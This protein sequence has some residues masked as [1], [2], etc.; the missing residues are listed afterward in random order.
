MKSTL[1]ILLFL[2]VLFFTE[3]NAQKQLSI[4]EAIKIALT[5]NSKLNK[6]K[7]GLYADEAKV[8]NAYG[9]LLPNLSA[10][11][12]MNWQRNES[13]SNS[14]LP[15]SGESRNYT[16]GIGGNWTLFDGLSN[17]YRVSAGESE[18]EAARYSLEKFKQDVVYQTTALFYDVINS[19]KLLE[20]SKDNLAY[21]K[22]FLEQIQERNRLG[23]VALADVYAQQVQAGT[24]E[25]QYI[26]AQNNVELAKNNLFDF[27]S[28]DVMSEYE[29]IEPEILKSSPQEDKFLEELESMESLMK[30]AIEK[31]ADYISSKLYY[32]A[33]GSNLSAARGGLFPSLSANYSYGSSADRIS[34]LFQ[35]KTYNLGLTLSIPIF[36]NW[37]TEYGI[38]AAKVQELSLME[39]LSDMERQIKIDIKQGYLDLVASRKKLEVSIKNVK[40]AYENRRINTERYNLGAGTILDFLAGEKNYNQALSDNINSTFEY[41]KNR[42]KLLNAMGILN[43]ANYEN[44]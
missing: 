26:Q 3:L 38:Q 13:N 21:N 42:D 40:A 6:S 23:S 12:S 2:S 10:S 34:N 22:K 16:A 43:Y 15:G 18:L 5:N 36:S 28:M 35:N 29:I 9:S 17:I 7:Y 25:L 24:A 1:S 32:E 30:T 4:D 37:S 41:Y 8:K 31:R 19:I 39:D 44:N 33:A 11:G 27:L 14:S 20:V